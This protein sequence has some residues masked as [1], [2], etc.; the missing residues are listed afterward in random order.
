MASKELIQAVKGYEH[1]ISKNGV[2]ETVLKA[3]GKA[4][5]VAIVTE[6]DH[7]YGLGIT[8]K[9]KRLINK[10]LLDKQG[11]DIW[12]LEKWASEN[13]QIVTLVELYYEMLLLETYDNFESF[14]LYMERKR[15]YTKRFY[16][17]RRKTLHVVVED[18]QLL[19]DGRYKFYGLSMPARTG[20]STI[21]IFFLCWVGLKR[22]NAHNAMGGHSGILAKGF[23]KE[24]LNFVTTEEYTYAEMYSLW[25]P[26]C[27]LL[28]DKSADEYT[29][30]LDKPDR[31]AT[32]TCRGID[33]T[34]TGAVDIS[35]DGYLYVD[36]LVRDREHS[37]SPTRMENT[38]REYQNKMVDRKND[39]AKELMVGTLWN[40]LD[41]LERIRKAHEGDSDYFFR[42]IPALNENDESNFAYEVN[43]FSTE[44]Y[45][46]LRNE[47]ELADWMAK[48]QQAPFVREGLTFPLDSLRYFDGNVPV[49]KKHRV[50]AA[51][52][53]AF[54]G[55]DSASMP[56]CDDYGGT[57]KYII[58]WVHDKRSVGY[59][60]PEI[61]DKICEHYITKLKIEKNRGGDLFASQV[62]KEMEARGVSH[63]KIE[64]KNAPNTISKVDKIVGY[65]DYVK[66][67]FIFLKP[68]LKKS[69][70]DFIYKPSDQY[71]KALDEMGM[72]SAEGKNQHED[73]PDGLTQLAMMFDSGKRRKTKVTKSRI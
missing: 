32:F 3:M 25:H 6:G 69:T 53:P 41:P 66:K 19:E 28:T 24:L 33:G 5:N 38:Y 68:E 15:P 1:Y 72:F 29:I 71:I 4:A 39:G 17:P 23:H 43:G 27:D 10:F 55:G 67:N 18:L 36:D 2:D 7:D 21:C 31:F 46:N 45:K 56:I 63:C 20:K 50:W 52:D 16:Q 58:D 60:V 59:T 65:S 62:Q 11:Y 22:P 14:C 8:D 57:E 12:K 26:G 30:T 37:L 64:L 49:E 47:L 54:G 13:G 34:W 35:K 9:V 61:V 70:D 73:S 40:V 48:Y 42:K 44:Y 51:C